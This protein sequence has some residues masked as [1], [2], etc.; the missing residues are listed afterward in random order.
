MATCGCNGLSK[1]GANKEK[2]QCGDRMITVQQY[3]ED[4]LKTRLQYPDLP[5]VWVGPRDKKNY[6]PMEVIGTLYQI[7]NFN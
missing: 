6:V 3:F 5:C 1:L 4:K 2:F 7:V